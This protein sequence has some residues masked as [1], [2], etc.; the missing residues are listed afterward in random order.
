MGKSFRMLL[1]EII[2]AYTPFSC[3]VVTTNVVTASIWRS[4]KL[5]LRP[6]PQITTWELVQVQHQP[7]V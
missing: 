3:V 2:Y 6:I 5:M 1:L 4:L 7:R